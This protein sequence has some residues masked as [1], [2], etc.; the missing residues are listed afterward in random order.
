[1][2]RIFA[3]SDIHYG[4]TIGLVAPREYFGTRLVGEPEYTFK[5]LNLKGYVEKYD[6]W[7][8]GERLAKIS[9]KDDVLIIAGDIDFYFLLPYYFEGFKGKKIFVFGNH[10]YWYADTFN[11]INEKRDWFPSWRNKLHFHEIRDYCIKISKKFFANDV[12]HESLKLVEEKQRYLEEHDFIVMQDKNEP[13]I[14][15]DCVIVADGLWYDYSFVDESRFHQRVWEK[16]KLGGVGQNNDGVYIK[17]IGSDKEFFNKRIQYYKNQLKIA[18]ETKKPIISAC[19]FIPTLAMVDP[20][21]TGAYFFDAFLGSNKIHEL[22]KEFKVDTCLFGHI[23][24]YEPQE[25]SKPTN[26]IID[27]VRYHNVS[28]FNID[29]EEPVW[30]NKN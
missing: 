21:F 16:K 10:D 20:G 11:W 3:I 13:I 25:K 9:K 14:L 7:K 4:N 24:D 19:H 6:V 30:E 29:H 12:L 2:T 18:L 15:D 26:K 28:L 27:G 8:I 22:N 5:G 1:M 23:H 17:R